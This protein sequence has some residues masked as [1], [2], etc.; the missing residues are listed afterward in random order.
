VSHWSTLA[1]QVLGGTMIS[2]DDCVAR[3]FG[4]NPSSGTPTR[5]ISGIRAM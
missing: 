1:E 4:W 2:A 5:T 3:A